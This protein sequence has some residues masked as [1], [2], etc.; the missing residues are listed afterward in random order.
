[1]AAE[2]L[3]VPISR[4]LV[5]GAEMSLRRSQD[6]LQSGDSIVVILRGDEP[7]RTVGTLARVV[8]VRPLESGDTMVRLRGEHL[9]RVPPEAAAGG[10]KRA[11]VTAV[12]EARSADAVVGVVQQA[13]SRYMAARAESGVGGNVYPHLSKD[14]VAASHEV[15]SH[16]QISWPELQEVLEAGD[17]V[18][19]L[20]KGL[21]IMERETELLR[22]LLASEGS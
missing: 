3:I 17:A 22:R 8:G 2:A 21:A 7:P 20:R 5:P 14:P 16:L 1:M 9:V 15:A 4:A 13:L 10:E 6:D 19:R 11:L 18:E 12:D